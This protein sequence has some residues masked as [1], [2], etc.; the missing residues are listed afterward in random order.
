MKKRLALILTFILLISS[1]LTVF[2][3]CKKTEE[4]VDVGDSSNNS[5]VS[6]EEKVQY[7][8]EP[9]DLGGFTLDILAVQSGFWNMHTDLA[10]T[11][12][13][14]ETINSAVYERN[15]MVRSLYNANIVAHEDVVGDGYYKMAERLS[16]DQLSGVN[17]Y[18]TAYICA[19]SVTSLINIEAL[20]NLYSL[21]EIQLDKE[22]W[23]PL[24]TKEATLGSGKY[25][26]LFFTQSNLS[27]TAFDLTWCVYF[28]KAVHQKQQIEDLYALVENGQWTIEKMKTIAKSVANDNGDESFAYKEDGNA[29]YGITTYWN[30]AKALLDGGN[31][32]YVTLDENG[33]P[34][35]NITNERFTNLT[36]D[37]AYLFGEPGTFTYGGP[38][39]EGNTPGNAGDYI[40]IFN[41]GRSLFCIA[42]VKSSVSDFKSFNGDFGILPLPK[43]ESDPQVNYR[44]WTNY[45]S[46]VLVIPNTLDEATTHNTALLLDV[47]SFYSERDL[48]PEYYHVVL[49]GRGA[50]D[51]QSLNMLEII[52]ETRT[53]DSS[54]A[55]EWT[56]EFAEELSKTI[57]AGVTDVSSVVKNYQEKIQTNIKS[58]LDKIYND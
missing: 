3:G 51:A 45:I 2:S 1:I 29:F 17:K 41:A 25:S 21:P 30:G 52:N 27:L 40:K 42:E 31:V 38:S 11:T 7:N 37:L 5:S 9:E 55:Y 39:K 43:Y 33:D 10:P 4:G 32:K 58:T 15:E 24:V 49:E 23:S 35:P 14:G 26:T 48:L 19:S 20:V 50:K 28:N 16:Q 6:D 12:Y 47:L 57:L 18:D 53:F 8:R 44:S 36:Q 56:E 13:N 22:W 46:P 34:T 54:L